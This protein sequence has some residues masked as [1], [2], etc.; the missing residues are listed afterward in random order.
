[1]SRD[2]ESD[3]ELSLSVCLHAQRIC[4][5]ILE[6]KKGYKENEKGLQVKMNEYQ[7]KASNI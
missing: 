3:S 2:S 7:I 1:M 5:G 4:L 6:D